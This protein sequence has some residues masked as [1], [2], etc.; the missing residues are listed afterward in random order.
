MR[1]KTLIKI[2]LILF[3]FP[4]TFYSFALNEHL[5]DIQQRDLTPYTEKLKINRQYYSLPKIK[6]STPSFKIPNPPTYK[7][8]LSIKETKIKSSYGIEKEE[9]KATELKTPHFNIDPT[10]IHIIE[11][12]I[13]ISVVAYFIKKEAKRKTGH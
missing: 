10:I 6:D 2:I 13:V 8:P 5:K 11:V 7:S 3:I 12:V 9:K 4:K 1:K